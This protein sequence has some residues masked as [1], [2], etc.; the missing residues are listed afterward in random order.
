MLAL[1]A[2]P[3][4]ARRAR[5]ASTLVWAFNIWGTLDLLAAIALATACEAAPFMGPAYWIPAYWVSA[6]LVTHYITFV[7]LSRHKKPLPAV[8][9]GLLDGSP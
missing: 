2:I 4:V 3:G 1:A 8:R 9:E 7:L 6:R 5:H